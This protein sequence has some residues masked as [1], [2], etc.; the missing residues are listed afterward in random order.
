MNSYLE[1]RLCLGPIFLVRE[2]GIHTLYEAKKS[3]NVRNEKKTL[4]HDTHLD[5]ELHGK[6]RLE[7]CVYL[8]T[9]RQ[10]KK[11]SARNRRETSMRRKQAPTEL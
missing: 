6:R 2:S 3:V 7:T 9:G 11:K 4:R 1:E 8:S 5:Y 10:R